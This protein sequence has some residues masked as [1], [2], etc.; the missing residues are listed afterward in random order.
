M[1]ALTN[2]STSLAV[3][4]FWT[5]GWFL[6][7]RT[8][9]TDWQVHQA[10]EQWESVF[11]RLLMTSGMRKWG[12]PRRCWSTLFRRWQEKKYWLIWFNSWTISLRE[13]VWTGT[14]WCNIV[15]LHRAWMDDLYFFKCLGYVLEL[16]LPQCSSVF[17]PT[18]V[19]EWEWLSKSGQ[20]RTSV[21]RRIQ[22][23]L[24]CELSVAVPSETYKEW[25]LCKRW[26]KKSDTSF[27]NWRY[28]PWWKSCFMKNFI[29]AV[30]S[31]DMAV[32]DEVC[33]R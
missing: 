31:C 20:V 1:T 24:W 4:F 6:W 17:E 28:S 11:R 14:T 19:G 5:L 13:D 2:S 16:P 22:N 26:K 30:D 23:H 8:I 3:P 18:E 29:S 25:K 10:L 21:G 12:M 9:R 33:N 15:L 7:Q 27:I 32:K